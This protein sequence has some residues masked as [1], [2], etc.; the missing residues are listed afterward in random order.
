MKFG[1]GYGRPIAIACAFAGLVLTFP[2]HGTA[3]PRAAELGPSAPL[4]EPSGGYVGQ[5]K[6]S[7]AH[8]PVGTLLTVTGEGF[9]AGQEF[10]LVWGTVTGS[11]KVS[12]AEYFAGRSRPRSRFISKA[13]AGANPPI[14]TPWS[15]TMAT[16]AMPAASTA[17]AMS[18]SSCRPPAS[19]AGTSSISIPRFSCVPHGR[20]C[21]SRPWPTVRRLR[22]ST[23]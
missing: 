1:F 10:D 9:A 18:R 5:I 4:A 12:N 7:P 16:A 2:Q 22:G 17:R 13:W 8:G 15:T 3:A 21:Q 20:N 14:S 6:V 19:P 11:W 23:A